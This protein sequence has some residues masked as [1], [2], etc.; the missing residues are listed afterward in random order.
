MKL[1]EQCRIGTM[2]L[3]N[4]IVL[5]P[6][7]NNLP[8][9]GFVTKRMIKFFE[10]RAKG[11]VGLITIGDGIVEVPLG[12]NATES[13]S[14]D[15]DKYIPGL[16]KLTSA[17][18]AHGAKICLQLSHGGRRAGLVG[19]DGYLAFT[20]GKIPVGPSAIA[21]PVTGHVVPREL[22]K[23]E[24]REIVEKFGEAARRSIKAGFDA[25]GLHCAHMYLCGEFLSPWANQRTDEYGRDIE[26]RLKFVL[27]IIERI[28]KETGSK[29]PLIV[30]MNG[31][32]PEGGNTLEEIRKIA[33]HFEKAGV[34][35]INV[36]I[37]I[38][39]ANKTAGL[40]PASAPMRAPAGVLLQLVENIKKGVSIPVIA[41]NKLG[42]VAFAEKVLQEGKAEFIAMARPLIADPYLPLKAAKG[43]FEEIRPCIYCSQGCLQN[44]SEKDAPIACSINPMAGRE[45]ERPVWAA[46]KK[47][48]ILIIGAGPSGMQAAITAST[49]GHK[50]TLVEKT[51][52]MGGELNIASKP[53]GKK[54]IE[55]YR[56]YLVNQVKKSGVQVELNKEVTLE[57][58]NEIQADAA[59]IATGGYPIIPKI[60][61]LSNQRI[62]TPGEI[63]VG[64]KIDAKKILII[65]GGQVGCEVAEFLC[66][67]GNEVTI[68]EI[69]KDIAVGMGRVNRLPLIV[70]LES[71]GVRIMRQTRVESI[72]NKGVWV[73]SAGQKELIPTDG[74]VIAVGKVTRPEKI[75]KIIRKKVSKVYLI[76]DKVKS[77]GI[78]EAVREGFDV[79]KRI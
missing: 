49:R 18:K 28:K 50:V 52:K 25:I 73:N 69:L 20:K 47:K 38:G 71:H 26:G 39:P 36:S 23:E 45:I 16:K 5:A 13:I 72:T 31:Q 2:D 33:C 62:F 42:N 30:R 64:A 29:Y 41:V 78:L 15:E 48:K 19:K 35:A 58:L 54:D 32:E 10:E 37:G 77:R 9:N 7:T 8:K 4:R 60:K 59:I 79:A 3:K 11:G 57:W 74:I 75:E 53:P 56:T 68:I 65:G 51:D 67:Q 34:D 12:K 22:T 55:P 76:G 63:L 27:E 61:G 1:F 66:E 21:H 14:I 70:S 43:N 6:M 40:I 17:V 24:I 44:V 46:K